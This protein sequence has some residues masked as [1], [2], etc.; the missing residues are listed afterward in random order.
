VIGHLSASG[1]GSRFG[2]CYFLS[3]FAQILPQDNGFCANEAIN[4][5]MNDAIFLYQTDICLK[6]HVKTPYGWRARGDKKKKK[7]KKKKD[8][9]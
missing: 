7:K 1:E 3:K 4:V 6:F 8:H 2:S 5:Q 9:E